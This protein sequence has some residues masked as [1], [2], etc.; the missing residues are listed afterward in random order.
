M[1]A[2]DVD[3]D[4]DDIVIRGQPKSGRGWKRVKTTRFFITVACCFFFNDFTICV[5]IYK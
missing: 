4:H 2:L 3:V 1:S 5:I